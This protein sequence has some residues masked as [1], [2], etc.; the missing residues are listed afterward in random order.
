VAIISG[1]MMAITTGAHWH[2]Q[3]TCAGPAC[4]LE[5]NPCAPL[6]P[7]QVVLSQFVLW[8]TRVLCNCASAI[9]TC[10][11]L[12]QSPNATHWRLHMQRPFGIYCLSPCPFESVLDRLIH[13]VQT[14]NPQSSRFYSCQLS[15]RAPV[16]PG[17]ICLLLR[18][19]NLL[20]TVTRC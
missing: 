2:P 20:P 13:P 5:Y 6:T 19:A 7:S 3:M 9:P 15:N 11:L 1:S 18:A 14:R 16:H 4:T 8:S 10:V 17:C 12:R